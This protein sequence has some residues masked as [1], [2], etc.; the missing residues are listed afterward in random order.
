MSAFLSLTFN[1]EKVI[2][3]TGQGDIEQSLLAFHPGVPVNTLAISR[4]SGWVLKAAEPQKG[5]REV[6]MAGS[7]PFVL[8]EQH[9]AQLHRLSGGEK[10]SPTLSQ[11]SI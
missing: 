8:Q 6:P 2:L 9:T 5:Q 4:A 11:A 1:T 3:S 7:H 10:G